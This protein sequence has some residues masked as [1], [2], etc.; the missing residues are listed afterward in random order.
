MT[1]FDYYVRPSAPVRRQT[2][3]PALRIALWLTLTGAM[4]FWAVV[5]WGGR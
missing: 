4:A 3:W 5:L 2:D 1:R